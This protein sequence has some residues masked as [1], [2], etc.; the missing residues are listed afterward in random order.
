MNKETIIISLGGSLVAP[1]DIDLG[2]LKSFKHSLQKYLGQKRFFIIVGGGKVCRRLS[3]SFAGVWRK[4]QRQ[5][6][7]WN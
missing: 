1:N 3:K 7:D 6:L 5:G 2:F 4:I